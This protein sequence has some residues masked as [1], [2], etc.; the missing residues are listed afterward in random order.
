LGYAY[1]HSGNRQAASGFLQELTDLAQHQYVPPY[2]VALVHAGLHENDRAFEWLEKAY[3]EHSPDL[4]FL[5]TEPRWDAFRADGR[6][7]DLLAR[8]GFPGAR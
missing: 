4:V 2:Y 5:L 1:A 6:F 7:R 8:V 3:R